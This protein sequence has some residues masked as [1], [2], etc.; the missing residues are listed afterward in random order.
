M[1]K[2]YLIVT[3]ILVVVLLLFFLF[4]ALV[5]LPWFLMH[6]FIAIGKISEKILPKYEHLFERILGNRY[7]T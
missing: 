5:L 3:G 2:F 7:K 4:M 6:I 1:Q